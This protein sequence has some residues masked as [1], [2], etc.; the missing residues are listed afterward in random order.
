MNLTQSEFLRA[1][2]CPKMLWMDQHKSDEI[3]KVVERD[4]IFRYGSEIKELARTSFGDYKLIQGKD[5]DRMMEE[6]KKY[7]SSSCDIQYPVSK[8]G[9]Y[10]ADL[11]YQYYILT[12]LGFSVSKVK[13]IQLNSNYIREEE[14]DLMSL[15]QI[16]DVTDNV[17]DHVSLIEQKLT[18]IKNIDHKS[19]KG[20]PDIG[21]QC[22]KPYPCSYWKYCSRLIERPSVF[23]LAGMNKSDMF[24]LYQNNITTFQDLLQDTSPVLLTDH[25]IRQIEME[26]YQRKPFLMKEKMKRYL[27]N[28]TYPLYFLDFESYQQAIPQYEGSTPYLQIPFQYSLHYYECKGSSLVHKEFLGEV[29]SDPRYPLAKRL[30]EDIPV[31]ACVVAYNMQFEKAII[32]KLAERYEDLKTHLMSIHDHIV[33]LIEPFQKH[34]YYQKEFAGYTSIKKVLPALFPDDPVLDYGK[35]EGIHKGDEAMSSYALL[36][37]IQKEDPTQAEEIKR[38]L[39]NYCELDTYAMVR[40]WEKLKEVVNYKE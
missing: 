35:L 39:L 27:K 19:E 17:R 34:Y 11:T 29:G 3:D 7:M 32:R 25:Q 22:F 5:E 14:L 6:T 37:K 2:Q 21:E 4:L 8:M 16:E 1:M 20:L 15:F 24:T 38:Q 33:D 40:I 23:D 12:K 18:E 10:I 30:C 9:M 31:N 13:V 28:F 26:F 36:S